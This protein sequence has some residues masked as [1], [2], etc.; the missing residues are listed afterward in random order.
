[1]IVYADSDL[2][3]AVEAAHQALFFNAGQ[4][5]AAGSRT[6]VQAEIYDEFVRKCV[7]RARSRVI[8]DPMKPGV[9]QGPQVTQHQFDSV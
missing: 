5:C 3:L 8:G 4:C 1:M 7:T 9:E 2:D 6:Y